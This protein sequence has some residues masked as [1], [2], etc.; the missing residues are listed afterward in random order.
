MGFWHV[1][2]VDQVS[3]LIRGRPFPDNPKIWPGFQHC[4]DFSQTSWKFLLKNLRL[5]CWRRWLE[6]HRRSI[7]RYFHANQLTTNTSSHSASFGLG[8][9][10]NSNFAALS[11]TIAIVAYSAANTYSASFGLGRNVK[12]NFQPSSPIL[13]LGR[14][15]CTFKHH[16]CILFIHQYIFC[17][18]WPGLGEKPNPKP[19]SMPISTSI[20]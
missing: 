20:L 16:C 17:R 8:R 11:A 10:A 5:I 19:K 13:G 9:D 2:R 1:G 14:D 3:S 7:E 18:F 15:C 12:P 6:V 4:Y